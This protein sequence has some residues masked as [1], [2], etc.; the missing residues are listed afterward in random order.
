MLIRG[1][2]PTPYTLTYGA[3]LFFTV[4][5][6]GFIQRTRQTTHI[7]PSA[8]ARFGPEQHFISGLNFLS[9]AARA[10]I[11]ARPGSRYYATAGRPHGFLR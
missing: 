3:F 7:R 6:L 4:L 10:A 2:T 8:A 11:N 5:G 1:V 9:L